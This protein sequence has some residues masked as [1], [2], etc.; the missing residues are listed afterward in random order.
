[1]IDC[2]PLDPCWWFHHQRRKCIYSRWQTCFPAKLFR[3]ATIAKAEGIRCRGNFPFCW[4]IQMDLTRQSKLVEWGPRVL[5]TPI[6]RYRELKHITHYYNECDINISGPGKPWVKRTKDQELWSVS[7][8]PK[9]VGSNKH[10]QITPAWSSS[11]DSLT[12]R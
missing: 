10:L 9:T 7:Q 6:R 3:V 4:C 12:P 1:M 8:K 11:C 5:L 2:L